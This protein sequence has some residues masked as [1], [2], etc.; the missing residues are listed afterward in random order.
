MGRKKIY[1]TPEEKKKANATNQ[2]RFYEKN[3]EKLRE[4]RMKRYYEKEK[5]HKMPEGK[6]N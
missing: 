6:N 5:M 4:E 2:R 3:K 1:K